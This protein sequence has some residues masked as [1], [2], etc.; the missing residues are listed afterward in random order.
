MYYVCYYTFLQTVQ[1]RCVYTACKTITN[2]E[3]SGVRV[4]LYNNMYDMYIT[5]KYIIYDRLVNL[6]K[7]LVSCDVKVTF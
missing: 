4:L 6:F 3:V 2:N 1:L 7:L 5:Y